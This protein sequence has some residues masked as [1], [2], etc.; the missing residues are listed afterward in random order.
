MGSFSLNVSLKL[1]PSIE[2]FYYYLLIHKTP[3][4]SFK[5]DYFLVHTPAGVSSLSPRLEMLT[6][7]AVDKLVISSV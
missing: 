5:M 3:V 6:P 4:Y 1:W 7:H 2:L